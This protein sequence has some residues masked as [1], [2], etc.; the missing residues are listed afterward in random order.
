MTKQTTKTVKISTRTVGQKFGTA[1]VVK[2]RNG[3]V[4]H[5]CSARP[6][7]FTESAESDARSYA[8]RNGMTIVG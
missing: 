6:Y 8:E 4:L 2:A 5:V 3:R 1:G 7:G